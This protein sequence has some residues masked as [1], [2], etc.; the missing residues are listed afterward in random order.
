MFIDE[1][2]FHTNGA[3][4]KHNCHIWESEN[5]HKIIQHVCNSLIS[6][7]ANIMTKL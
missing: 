6:G 2:T 7:V 5:P 3:V 1:A 4:N